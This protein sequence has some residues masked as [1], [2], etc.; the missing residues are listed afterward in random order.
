MVVGSACAGDTI[1]ALPGGGT[2][3]PNQLGIS[4]R[5]FKEGETIPVLYTCDGENISPPLTWEKPPE[6]TQSLVLIVD[7]PD[8]PAGI[9]VHWVLYDIPASLNSLPE[10]IPSEKVVPDIG[11]Q[12]I[13][14]S[15]KIGY[16]GPCP[17][18][19]NP[20]RYFFKLYALD[21][22]LNLEPGASKAAVETAMQGSILVE[23]Q[24]IGLYG[25]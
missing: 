12:G 3:M 7:D 10:G 4:S 6:G 5:A 23:G 18:G 11:T 16:G 15:R 17:P 22:T 1:P 20:H 2:E 8:A 9:W 21:S 13:N 19:G 25:R 24:L 14:D